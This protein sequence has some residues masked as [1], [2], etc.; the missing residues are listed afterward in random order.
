MANTEQQGQRSNKSNPNNQAY[1]I[2]SARK[3]GSNSPLESN[4]SYLSLQV[5][6]TAYQKLLRENREICDYVAGRG[7]RV[8][9]LVFLASDYSV[10]LWM[11][12]AARTV[13]QVRDG[14]KVEA[15]VPYCPATQTIAGLEGSRAAS[16]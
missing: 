16:K 2:A 12:R 10:D 4:R 8:E 11:E 1:W 15:T 6:A 14:G 3:K 5:L 7:G 13:A 9:L